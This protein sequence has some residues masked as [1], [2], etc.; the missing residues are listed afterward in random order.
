[1]LNCVDVL[2]GDESFVA[3]RKKRP[4]HRTLVAIEEQTEIFYEEL[5][6]ETRAARRTPA[7]ELDEAQQAFDK[8]VDQVSNRPDLDERTKEIM[9]DEPPG[10]RPASARRRRQP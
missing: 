6:E 10:G 1:M 8:Q 2:A 4:R 5:D 9:L 7:K 3:L